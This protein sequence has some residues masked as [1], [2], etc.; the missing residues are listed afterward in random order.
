MRGDPTKDTSILQIVGVLVRIM[1]LLFENDI[2][3]SD[4]GKEALFK[5]IKDVLPY[6]GVSCYVG[7]GEGAIVALVMNLDLEDKDAIEIMQRTIRYC[8]L[9]GFA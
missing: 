4:K 8:K 2:Y 7:L 9:W 6:I 5:A 1:D 3:L